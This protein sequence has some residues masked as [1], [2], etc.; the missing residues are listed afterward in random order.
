MGCSSKLS[1]QSKGD[2]IWLS[3]ITEY[4]ALNKLKSKT[5]TSVQEDTVAAMVQRIVGDRASDF[6]I[7]VDPSLAPNA[8][9]TFRV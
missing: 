9:D 2:E 4:A 1:T 8:P 3:S 7:V 5:P 6:I